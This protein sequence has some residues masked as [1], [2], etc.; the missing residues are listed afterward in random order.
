MLSL[1]MMSGL[2][3]ML[4][5][6]ARGTTDAEQPPIDAAYTLHIRIWRRVR[7]LFLTRSFTDLLHF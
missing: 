5:A 1:A 4:S 7:A 2:L 3:L 6:T